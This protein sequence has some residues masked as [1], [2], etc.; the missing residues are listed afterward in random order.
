[1]AR[2]RSELLSTPANVSGRMTLR[3]LGL[4]IE[5]VNYSSK[6][7]FVKG[8]EVML[9]GTIF[10]IGDLRFRIKPVTLTSKPP[11]IGCTTR[12]LD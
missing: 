7:R 3:Y 9:G 10:D 2:M 5:F 8:F 4:V 6:I 12:S 1:M 11:E